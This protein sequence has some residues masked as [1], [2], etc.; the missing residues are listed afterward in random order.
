MFYVCANDG[1]KLAVED[2]NPTSEKTVIFVHGWPLAKEMYEYQINKLND[3][4]YRII[5][6]DLRGF[7]ESEVANDGYMYDQLASD[8]Y[9]VMDTLQLSNVT[10]V[11][12]SMGGAICVRYMNLFN[13]KRVAKLVLAGAAV[14]S[15]TVSMN[16][17]YGNS[18][19]DTNTLIQQLYIDR[20]K[21]ASDFGEKVFALTTS[22]PFMKWF[23]SLS[24]KASGIGT[25]KSAISLRD[26]DVYLDLFNIS[27]PTAILH[28][29]LD[30]ICP[31]GFAKIMQQSIPNSCLYE[32]EYSGHGL[33]YD[34]RNKFNKVLLEF[35]ES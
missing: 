10:L 33:F 26:E 24:F 16:N 21:T 34:E 31:F 17:P 2:I 7:G 12:F 25:I 6:F 5:S 30:T 19:K 3:R 18:I 20:P 9:C 13:N 35:I 32:F 1:I 23:T 15:Y 28:G 4:G 11:G 22:T 27:V 8:L 14:P 29:K